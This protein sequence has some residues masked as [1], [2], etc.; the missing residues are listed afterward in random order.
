MEAEW[1]CRAGERHSSLDTVQ[2][3]TGG[4]RCR[5]ARHLPVHYALIAAAITV[6]FEGRLPDTSAPRPPPA[7]GDEHC[8][9]LKISRRRGLS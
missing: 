7:W 8:K 2:G 5:A 3:G 9:I 6:T 1:A 4:G